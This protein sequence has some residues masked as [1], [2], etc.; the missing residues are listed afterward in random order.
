M[1][2]TDADI[3]AQ[4]QV[5]LRYSGQGLVLTVDTSAE[6]LG[7]QGFTA[8]AE[9]FDRLHEQ[10]FTFALD[11][12]KEFVNLRVVVEGPATH[13]AAVELSDTVSS[14]ADAAV[15]DH[16]I[17]ADGSEHRAKLYDRSRL[18]P[19]HVIA[20]PAVIM[21]MDSTTLVLPEHQAN[22][23]T[24]GNLL[25]SPVGWERNEQVTS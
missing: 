16:T 14:A 7:S 1:Q 22:I 18:H 24:V 13:I 23:D 25:I 9:Q 4:F 19:G 15:G 3:T 11:A 5:D 12:Q 17:F 6:E 8:I 10:L 21:E 2:V 20:G